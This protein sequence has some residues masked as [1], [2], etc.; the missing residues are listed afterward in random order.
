LRV[1]H[2]RGVGAEALLEV[3]V[4]SKPVQKPFDYT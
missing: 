1:L 3:N 4:L 2:I